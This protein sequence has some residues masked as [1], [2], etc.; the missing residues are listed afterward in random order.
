MQ[1]RGGL[2][3]SRS[4]PIDVR[5]ALL[6]NLEETVL[7]VCNSETETIGFLWARSVTACVLSNSTEKRAVIDRP[8][9]KHRDASGI[10]L[11]DTRH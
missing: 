6:T 9:R 7:V 10:D 11:T 8:Y 5:E 4:I 3:K 1:R 2:F